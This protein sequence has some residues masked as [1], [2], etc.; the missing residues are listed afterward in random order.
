MMATMTVRLCHG[1]SGFGRG[2]TVATA[3]V[4]H[5]SFFLSKQKKQVGRRALRHA[6]AVR[7]AGRVELELEVLACTDDVSRKDCGACALGCM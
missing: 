3:R 1:F 4:R 2:V 5:V 6:A 7:P